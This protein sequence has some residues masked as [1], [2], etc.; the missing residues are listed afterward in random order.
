M[1]GHYQARWISKQRA[2]AMRRS[3]ALRQGVLLDSFNGFIVVEP[4]GRDLGDG[5][6]L[7]RQ[8]A[9]YELRTVWC[10]EPRTKLAEARRLLG[11]PE[12]AAAG[13]PVGVG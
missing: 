13:V 6:V 3:G 4:P 9:D 12:D 11:L 8:T 7:S 2:D 10:L 5:A 1:R